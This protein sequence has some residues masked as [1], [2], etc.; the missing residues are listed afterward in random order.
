MSFLGRLFSALRKDADR[1]DP[2]GDALRLAEVEGV[3]EGIRPAIRAD[4]GEVWLI[5]V[6][7]A[8]VV[9]LRLEGACKSCHAQDMTLQGMLEPR[10]REA[11]PWI[12]Q[13][14]LE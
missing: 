5:A 1:P 8:G 12:R 6:E 11:L 9:R 3:L 7:E 10:L 14:Q 2:R 13:V 4:G